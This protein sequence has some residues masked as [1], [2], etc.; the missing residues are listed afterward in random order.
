MR[1]LPSRQLPVDQRAALKLRQGWALAKRFK[2][3][4]F[5]AGLL[6]GLMPL[7][8]TSQ[9]RNPD[10]SLISW[11]EALHH[12]YFLLFGQPSLAY[13]D[14][15]GV[16]ALNILIPPF[17]L[18][19]V[20][21]GGVRFAYL[22]FA[23]HRLEKE[24]IEVITESMRDHVVVCGAGRVG[25]RV[26]EQLMKVGQSVVVIEKNEQAHFASMLRDGNVPVLFDDIANP[27]S[28]ERVNIKTAQAIVCA[29]N[30]DLANLNVA[31]DARKLNPNLRIVLRLFDEDLVERVREN[32]HAEAHS[33]SALSA[34]AIALSALDPRVLHSF[35]VG[36]NLMVV[37]RFRVGE[38]LSGTTVKTI[39]D[40][41]GG[42]TLSLER[43]TQ[44]EVMH[45]ADE[46]TLQKGEVATVQLE[47]NDYLKLRAHTGE[48]A[49]GLVG[50]RKLVPNREAL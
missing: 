5:N 34:P 25:Y 6:F 20:V 37:S 11:G 46:T 31:L 32:F 43:A 12:V 27:K 9:Y 24:W 7:V 44:P 2:V 38:A 36:R 47:W 16:E 13:V 22:F 48:T 42:L 30:D 10:G 26:V 33:T 40:T 17:G 29:T 4:F 15:W 1:T 28:L 21:D 45:P 50:D 41:H 23:K 18:A 19:T 39:R 8:F 14:N 3:V 35:E 49:A